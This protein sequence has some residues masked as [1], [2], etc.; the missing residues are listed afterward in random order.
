MTKFS[1]WISQLMGL[2]YSF[3]QAY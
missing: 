3:Q 1:S 2:C